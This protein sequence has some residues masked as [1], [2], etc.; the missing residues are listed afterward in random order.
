[1]SAS[2]QTSDEIESLE[3]I[4]ER[5]IKGDELAA[6]KRILYGREVT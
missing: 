5:N 1:M 4:L 6:V 3:S 2:K